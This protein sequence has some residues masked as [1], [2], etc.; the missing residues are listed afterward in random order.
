[1]EVQRGAVLTVTGTDLMD[2]QKKPDIRFCVPKPDD[3]SKPDCS[4][5]PIPVQFA[6]DSTSSAVKFVVP[7]GIPLGSYTLQLSTSSGSPTTFAGIRVVAGPTITGVSPMEVQ[8]GAILTVNG[9]NLVQPNEPQITFCEPGISCDLAQA[10]PVTFVSVAADSVKFIVPAKLALG[11]YTLKLQTATEGRPAFIS[12]V[13]VVPPPLSVNSISPLVALPEE[14]PVKGNAEKTQTGYHINVRGSGFS[15]LEHIRENKLLVKGMDTLIVCDDEPP[16]GYQCVR[17]NINS[18]N[19]EITFSGI[20]ANYA[21]AR[22][23]QLQVDSGTPSA[24]TNISFSYFGRWWPLLTTIVVLAVL[25]LII[26]KILTAS[27]RA[28]PTG[29]PVSLLR[30]ALLDTET[31]TYSL[32]KLQFY[33]WLFAGLASYIYLSIAK[34]LVQGIL[35]LSEVPDNLP[36]IAAISVGT[37]VL[38]T[39]VATMAG[40]K[41]SGDVEPSWS[42]LITSGG[43]VAPERLQFLLWNIVGGASYLFYTF[44]ISPESIKDLPTIPNTFLQIMGVSSAGYVVGKIARGPGPVIKT[45]VGRIV[46][47]RY[48]ATL[49]GT[50]LATKGETFYWAT[51]PN[52]ND[53]KVVHDIV[54]DQ[55]EIDTSGMATKLVVNLTLPAGAAAPA[56]G[57]YRITIVNPD[58]EKSAQKITVT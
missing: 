13:R 30:L 57:D 44:L 34:S 55:S 4:A 7:V 48:Q 6:V 17:A 50:A 42:D 40:S 1:M 43:V 38:A 10:T 24:A 21:G 26:V 28:L 39:G 12:G 5:P 32:A 33:I 22:T 53:Q 14:S 3:S 49:Q 20:P 19:D 45:A 15:P 51:W 47:E 31:N 46:A 25:I 36:M 54:T 35:T 29:T 2:G 18:S 37:G 58:G 8:R 52:G 16:K 11:T 41:G 23:I 27:H 56:A 9:A